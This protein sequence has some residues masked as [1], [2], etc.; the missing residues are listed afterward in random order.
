MATTST[1]SKE[2]QLKLLCLG[3]PRLVGAFRKLYP[4]DPLP[5][6]NVPSYIAKALADG[7]LSGH[8]TFDDA[9]DATP[10]VLTTPAAPAAPP[11][12]TGCWPTWP[13]GGRRCLSTVPCRSCCR[14]PP[15]RWRDTPAICR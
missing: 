13:R 4:T 14:C 12:S 3:Q 7:I 6:V 10:I 2:L 5:S 11:L 9:K 1:T 15:I 8:F